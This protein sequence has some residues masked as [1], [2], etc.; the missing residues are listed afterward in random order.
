MAPRVADGNGRS[1]ALN[2]RAAGR[3][4]FVSGAPLGFAAGV[5]ML[6]VG[7]VPDRRC[8]GESEFRQSL[9][10]PTWGFG[11]AGGWPRIGFRLAQGVCQ[12]LVV[13]RVV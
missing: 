9:R 7:P 6:E 2:F 10:L 12:V 3:S 8:L 11:S 4:P 1:E 5:A 13:E